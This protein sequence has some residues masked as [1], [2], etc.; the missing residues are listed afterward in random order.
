VKAHFLFFKRL[1]YLVPVLLAMC[2]LV[3]L[4]TYYIPGDPARAALGYD[5]SEEMLKAFRSANGLDRPF[6]VQFL[7]YLGRLVRGDLGRSLLTGN[8]VIKDLAQRLP[9]TL[10]LTLSSVFIGTLIAIPIGVFAAIRR[11]KSIDLLI[12][13]PSFLLL[14]TPVFWSGI[15]FQLIFSAKLG[16]LPFGGRLAQAG[17]VIPIT[18]FLTIDALLRGELALFWDAMKHL[19]MP[20]CVLSAMLLAIVTRTVRSSMLE[21]LN[22][23]YIMVARAKGVAERVVVF[24]HALFNAFIPVVTIIGLRFGELL[25]GAVVTET[26]FQWPG[27]GQYAVMAMSRLD[28]TAIMGFTLTV[29]VMFALVNLTV[30]LLYSWLDPRVKLD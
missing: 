4:V 16:V 10:E 15:L 13:I 28:F 6:V 17:S 5:A 25:A 27:M 7:R 14:A 8:P 29:C 2:F 21:V 11:G 22:E 24:R 9:A 3:F 19:I 20:S 26:V 30:D 23:Q 18:G 1:L 12:R